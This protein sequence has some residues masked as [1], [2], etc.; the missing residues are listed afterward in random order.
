MCK[1]IIIITIAFKKQN[2]KLQNPKLSAL[3]NVER[4]LAFAG[5]GSPMKVVSFQQQQKK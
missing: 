3:I 5:Q 2:K 4:H 1:I